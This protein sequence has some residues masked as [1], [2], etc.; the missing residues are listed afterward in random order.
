[1]FE[2]ERK[3]GSESFQSTEEKIRKI[4]SRHC[5]VAEARTDCA[6]LS[7]NLFFFSTRTTS[8]LSLLSTFPNGFSEIAE[9]SGCQCTEMWE[10]EGLARS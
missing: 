6:P 9:A 10:E 1:M 7:L 4:F 8:P 3:S 2:M 5:D